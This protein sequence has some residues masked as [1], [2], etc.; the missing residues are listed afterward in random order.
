M[1]QQKLNRR[2]FVGM[3]AIAGGMS[4]CNHAFCPE[5]DVAEPTRETS[6]STDGVQPIQHVI[7]HPASPDDRTM[8]G[9]PP[10][11]E[12]LVWLENC[13]STQAR[14]RWMHRHMR[15]LVPTHVV[16]RGLVPISLL[17]VEA[18]DLSEIQV[19]DD[20]GGE[21]TVAEW[22]EESDTDAFLVM[23]DA[24]IVHEEYFHG[25]RAD[26]PHLLWSATKAIAS[27]VVANLLAQDLLKVDEMVTHYVPEMRGTGYDGA[28][29]RQC[30]DMRSGVA[31]DNESEG[32]QNTWNR[33]RR[34]NGFLA[35]KRDDEKPYQ[36]EYHALMTFDDFSQKHV[37]PHGGRFEYKDSDNRVVT[38]ACEKVTNTRFADLVSQF[39]WSK[40]GCEY[41]ADMLCDGLGSVSDGISVTLRDLARWGQMHL[42]RGHFNGEQVVPGP[43]IDD[44]LDNFDP[45]AITEESFL[46]PR[47]GV[48]RPM[49][50]RS[51]FWIDMSPGANAF[52]SSGYLGQ[53]CYVLPK[54]SCVIAKVAT[55]RSS[56]GWH[57]YF[58]KFRRDLAA[59]RKIAQELDG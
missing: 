48:P 19:P 16:R 55:W 40:L 33:Y 53:W 25:M 9:F 58:A 30:L 37:R 39:I 13:E 41:D 14:T 26:E 28:T 36:G 34:A 46:G 49:T 52:T 57:D 50:Y 7:S 47:S 31:W 18:V 3:A 10:P 21:T 54:Y 32:E 5:T 45:K 42:D 29:I 1:N 12:D 27:G 2:A 56:D 17:P 11:E 15:E 6:R 51:W 35:R 38:W 59:F 4:G 22:L 8:Q 23:H 43:F 44:I 24:K 20:D